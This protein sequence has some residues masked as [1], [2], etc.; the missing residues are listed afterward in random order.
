MIRHYLGSLEQRNY[1]PSTLK[2]YSNILKPLSAKPMRP[3]TLLEYQRSILPLATVT[4]LGKLS[5]LKKYLE[6]SHPT[7]APLVILPKKPF[8]LPKNIPAQSEIK[9]ILKKPDTTTF[10]GLRDRA[11][12]ELFYSTG[13]RRMEIVNLKIDDINFEKQIVR[14]NQGKGRKDR[15]V[16]IITQSLTW[17]AAYLKKV[18]PF[19]KPKG[20][21]LFLSR[22]G[23]AMHIG[24]PHQ[25]IQKYA[26]YSCHK[27]RHAFATHLLQNGMKETSLQQLLGHTQID[28]TQ[29]YTKVTISDLK[30]S[31]AKYHHRD[32]WKHG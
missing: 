1:A 13:M 18:R 8:V 22:G 16:P 7:L 10:S 30:K 25:I 2:L 27:Y 4:R 3:A 32:R 28:T 19:L 17:V 11:I 9:A 29:R 5:V 6:F 24:T 14:I 26:P 23:K 31:Y 20:D 12:L 15:L 21:T